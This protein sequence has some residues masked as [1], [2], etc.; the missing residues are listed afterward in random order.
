MKRLRYVL[1]CLLLYGTMQPLRPESPSRVETRTFYSRVLELER[2]YTIYLPPGYDES[3]ER[4]PVVYFFRNRETEWFNTNYSSRKGKALKE[5]ADQLLDLGLTGKMILVGPNSGG[6]SGTLGLGVN[7]LCPDS[8]GDVGTGRLEDHLVGEMIAHIDSAYR[9]IA[10]GAHRGTDGHSSGCTPAVVLA[11]HHPGLFSSV[12]AFDGDY[13]WY[14]L[15]PQDVTSTGADVRYWLT[16][17]PALFGNPHNIP[18]QLTYGP[19]NL[20]KGADAATLAKYRQIRFHL[21]TLPIDLMTN[22]WANRQLLDIMQEHG[23]YNT[24]RDPYVAPG[25]IHDWP[26]ADLHA[27]HSLVHHWQSFADPG[28]Q[29]A[30]TSQI[31]FDVCALGESDTLEAEICNTT[32]RPVTI[33]SF[34]SSRADF[35]LTGF[36]TLPFTLDSLYDHL[37]FKVVFAPGEAG[38]ISSL[39]NL[40][41]GPAGEF[42]ARMSVRGTGYLYTPAQS[43]LIYAT[44]SSD[45]FLKRVDL[46]AGSVTNATVNGT[47][48]K[49]TVLAIE[50]SSGDL[51]GLYASLS[52]CDFYRICSHTGYT[53]L[54]CT[55]PVGRILGMAFDARDSLYAGTADGKLYRI[56]LANG[57]ATL[58]GTAPGVVFGGLA[59]HPLTGQLYASSRSSATGKDNIYQ[60]NILDADTTLV[61]ATGDGKV[62][63]A[64]FFDGAGTLYALKGSPGQEYTLI[65]V[66]L[67]NGKGTTHCS[68]GKSNLVAMAMAPGT[69]SVSTDPVTSQPA[70]W[71]LGVNYP[72]PFNSQTTI[73][74]TAARPERMEVAVYN[75]LGER[76]AILHYGLLQ[77]GKHRLVWQGS[78]EAGRQLPSGLYVIRMTTGGFAAARKML[79]LR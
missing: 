77:A 4:Y 30:L 69:T 29:V 42:Q 32:N 50:P 1:V 67:A 78:N 74:V 5:V 21:E 20:I 27:A 15:D 76:V 25:A 16:W 18:Y 39:I 52:Q 26:W 47:G 61:G 48:I 36:P 14:N 31:Q 73:E 63:T 24:F 38:E 60:I 33:R 70:Q 72:N 71:Q 56:T 49:I 68:L 6:N 59:F 34:T 19:A 58:I 66:D 40:F 3:S 23:L 35:Q 7:F 10:D 79:L 9:T 12:G 8:A 37:T 75:M 13:I 64:I 55:V 53:K 44:A 65:T 11:L 41:S 54:L 51:I 45:Y 28:W 17:Y 62:S 57:A 22:G 43:G 46:A 2:N